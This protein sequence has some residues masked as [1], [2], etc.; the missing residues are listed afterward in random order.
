M[1]GLETEDKE[2]I[3]DL[4]QALSE[5]MADEGEKLSFACRSKDSRGQRVEDS[6][7]GTAKALLALSG[8]IR[9]KIRKELV[10]FDQYE[11]VVHLMSRCEIVFS[12]ALGELKTHFS[13]QH[14][15]LENATQKLQFYIEMRFAEHV[16]LLFENFMKSLFFKGLAPEEGGLPRFASLS[17]TFNPDARVDE[18]LSLSFLRCSEALNFPPNKKHETAY[19]VYHSMLTREETVVRRY[20][21]SSSS[22]RKSWSKRVERVDKTSTHPQSQ[23]PQFIMDRTDK[24]TYEPLHKML[25]AFFKL[26]T[27]WFVPTDEVSL[28]VEKAKTLSLNIKKALTA[29]STCRPIL[30]ERQKGSDSVYLSRSAFVDFQKNYLAE[31]LAALE[32]FVDNLD[33]QAV[34]ENVGRY[35]ASRK[36]YN[37]RS[38]IITG[39]LF[40]LL[41]H[42][43]YQPQAMTIERH[44]EFSPYG[45]DL[46]LRQ[47]C[48]QMLAR[49]GEKVKNDF[50]LDRTTEGAVESKF[51]EGN[52]TCSCKAPITPYI[53][54]YPQHSLSPPLSDEGSSAQ[55]VD[56]RS[57]RDYQDLLRAH[58]NGP[59]ALEPGL[60]ARQLE[61]SIESPGVIRRRHSAAEEGPP[62]PPAEEPASCCGSCCFFCCC[63]KA[64]QPARTPSAEPFLCSDGSPN[65][66]PLGRG[67]VN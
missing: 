25:Q 18:C 54:T 10:S 62:S 20:L 24:F 48:L 3:V 23:V 13:H 61:Y 55:Q 33:A 11:T 22:V 31:M 41:N 15:V 12:A 56:T 65:H 19:S 60:N 35:R 39:L 32:G 27:V 26:L 53:C 66:R 67:Q 28:K 59:N 44:K 17:L 47:A 9:E 46:D 29:L 6:E 37:L 64:E 8:N 38:K 43:L 63:K 1:S 5:K 58:L 4:L 16:A 30:N 2:R 40:S 57:G 51:Y 34:S 52:Y 50:T 7:S 45:A 14:V 42:L 49:L 21:L 36:S